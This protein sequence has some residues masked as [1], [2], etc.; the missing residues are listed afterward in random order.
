MSTCSFPKQERLKSRK[1]IQLLF[2]QGRSVSKYP[3]KII[4]SVTTI[5][6]EDQ[7]SQFAFSVPKKKIPKAVKRNLLKRRMLEVHRLNKSPLLEVLNRKGRCMKAMLI[8]NSNEI[9]SFDTITE[10]YLQIIKKLN[11]RT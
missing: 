8:Y 6:D 7:F 11:S 3:I 1:R 4:Y 5:S 9:L 10:S 2:Q